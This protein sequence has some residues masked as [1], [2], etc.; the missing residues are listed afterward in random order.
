LIATTTIITGVTSTFAEGDPITVDVSVGAGSGTPTGS[1]T[2]S[3]GGTQTCDITLDNGVGSCQITEATGGQYTFTADYGGDPSYALSDSDGFDVT[4]GG[5]STTTDIT[6]ATPLVAGQAITIGVS[7]VSDS[8]TPTGTVTVGDG[9]Q[10]CVATLDGSG[11]GSCQITETTSGSYTFTAVYNG[12]T[13]YVSSDSDST[14]ET[15]A[16]VGTTTSVAA[17]SP[18]QQPAPTPSQR[19]TPETRPTLLRQR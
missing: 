1:V 2:V 4:V 9:T 8:G 12:D 16:G 13:D 3:D 15:V 5:D 6:G 14:D 11:D 17:R 10:T 7:V 18:R 19:P